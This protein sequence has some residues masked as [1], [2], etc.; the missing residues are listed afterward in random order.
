MQLHPRV[1]LD[2]FAWKR[3]PPG[4]AASPSDAAVQ[5]WARL[6]RVSA[7]VRDAVEAELKAEGFPPLSWYDALLELERA[8]RGL[9]LFELER[10]M[11]LPQYATSRLV[12][13]LERAG[14]ARRFVCTQDGR[15]QVAAITDEGRD[16]RRRMWP[17]YAAAIERHVGARL[18]EAEAAALS[19]LLGKLGCPIAAAKEAV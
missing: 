8:G 15:G 12:D 7:A 9:R 18:T 14:L 4:M 13:R 6:V 3:Y 10:R 17:T 11:L 2:A 5:A 19:N 1:K 16:L